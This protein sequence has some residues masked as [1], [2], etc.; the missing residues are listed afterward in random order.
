MPGLWKARWL[1]TLLAYAWPT[2]PA[3]AH[4]RHCLHLR[5]GAHKPVKSQDRRLVL[6]LQKLL[7]W[8]DDSW[9][10]HVRE[11]VRTSKNSMVSRYTR[12]LIWKGMP[13]PC[14]MLR[15]LVPWL[16]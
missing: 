13:V 7:A 9:S 14:D 16:D 3:P 11:M 2:L 4:K 8:G 15:G 6:V 10:F 5:P 1:G 12:V